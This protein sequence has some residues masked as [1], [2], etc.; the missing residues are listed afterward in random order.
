MIM[1]LRVQSFVEEMA[2]KRAHKS[3]RE[4]LIYCVF[5]LAFTAWYADHCAHQLVA[6]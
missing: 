6:A 5:L 2:R 1:L 4:I 3:V